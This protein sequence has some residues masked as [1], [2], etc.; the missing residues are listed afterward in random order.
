MEES[1][2]T[3]SF[4]LGILTGGIVG[5]SVALLY[6]PKSGKELRNDIR[7]KKDELIDDTSE[8][9]Q[10]AKTKA[11]DLINEGRRKSEELISDAKKKASSLIDDAN[12]ILN[13]AKTKATTALGST[14][15]KITNETDRV[16]D[17][18]KAGLD[19]YNDEKEKNSE[20]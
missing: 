20:I 6:A 4:I 9:L 1:K 13:D 8:Y 11:G 19:A 14:K 18:F 10:I 2:T 15:D 12:V 16:K 17:A 3:K 5:A 7:L